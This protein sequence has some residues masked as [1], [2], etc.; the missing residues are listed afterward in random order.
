MSWR[1][2]SLLSNLR[3]ILPLECAVLFSKR[4][5]GVCFASLFPKR[6]SSLEGPTGSSGNKYQIP[7]PWVLS[8]PAATLFVNVVSG[9]VIQKVEGYKL[10]KCSAYQK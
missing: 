1:S 5:I 3:P 2:L 9:E 4:V 6:L 8:L 7:E 10:N